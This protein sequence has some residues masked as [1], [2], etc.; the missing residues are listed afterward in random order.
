MIFL[1]A[2]CCGFVLGRYTDLLKPVPKIIFSEPLI[3]QAVR[4]QIEKEKGTLTEEDLAEVRQIYIYGSEVYRDPDLF[5]RQTVEQHAEGTLR[6][7]D[8][9]GRLPNLEEIHISR[10]GYLDVS[11]IADLTQVYTVEIKHARISGVQ[12]IAHISKL[13]QAILFDCGLSDV[14]AL[15]GCPWL[16]TL[17]V[18]RND[19][20]DLKQIGSHP[21][22]RSL[23]FM[24]L[25]MKNVDDI[26]ER[27]PRLQAITLQHGEI[28]DMSGLKKLPDLS[29]V[30][31]LEE[32][33]EAVAELFEETDVEVH[34]T[35]N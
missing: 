15:E 30:Y 6:T 17:D 16:E 13:K 23:G 9:L 24:W 1:A 7:L 18:G 19:L 25:N 26:A 20:T 32:Q 14:T 27:L 35:E 11:G 12:P 10:Q 3:E 5:Y 34:V 22:V 33:Y 29:A 8:D 31:V 21:N 4:I 2:L 28:K